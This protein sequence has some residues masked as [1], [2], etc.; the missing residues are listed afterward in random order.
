[1]FVPEIV[2]A[3]PPTLEDDPG[4][5]RRRTAL[6]PGARPSCPTAE[7]ARGGAGRRGHPFGSNGTALGGD[8]TATGRGM[9][10]GNPHFPWQGRY[11]FTQAT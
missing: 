5:P 4:L 3:D 10:L 7:A 1:V 9:V 2:D 8:A 6:R 11:R